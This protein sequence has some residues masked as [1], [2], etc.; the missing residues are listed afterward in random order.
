MYVTGKQPEFF[1]SV[2]HTCDFN[3]HRISV[4]GLEDEV[5]HVA[6]D[7]KTLDSRLNEDEHGICSYFKGKFISQ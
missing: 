5:R 7:I 1:I 6:A 2:W 4:D 3:Y